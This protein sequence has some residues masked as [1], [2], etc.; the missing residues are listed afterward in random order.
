MNG[1]QFNRIEAL[2]IEAIKADTWAGTREKAR[3]ALLTFQAEYVLL[4]GVAGIQA[5]GVGS[6]SAPDQA[7]GIRANDLTE[8]QTLMVARVQRGVATHSDRKTL[9]L[10]NAVD[11]AP[12]PASEQKAMTCERINEIWRSA[13]GAYL[14]NNEFGSMVVDFAY[15]LLAAKGDG[16]AD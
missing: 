3:M 9:E 10:C 12:Q 7:S 1:E 16:H 4:H 2:L 14:D 15:A 11:A 8:L 5:N 6:G 13:N